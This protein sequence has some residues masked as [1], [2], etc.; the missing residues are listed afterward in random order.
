MLKQFWHLFLA[1]FILLLFGGQARAQTN[2][3][4]RW[5]FD[6]GG[7]VTPVLGT[8]NSKL[9][10]GWNITGGGGYNF[11]DNFGIVAQVMYDGL[12]VNNSVI[13][14]FQVPGAN[15]HIWG[16]TLNPEVRF[17]TSHRLG[18]YVIGGGG[19]YR[20]VINFT[21]PTT[22]V[23]NI[24]D[25]FFGYFYPTEV[26]ANQTIGTITKVGWGG[27][28]GGGLTYKLGGGP[29]R[30]FAEVRYHYIATQPRSI[31]IL[32]ITVGIRW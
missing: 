7:G 21:Q 5:N 26:A 25:P 22:E 18:A 20:R 11:N 27:N 12:G 8:A 1:S 4:G 28:I 16:F 15:S 19:Y 6:F 29:A 13:Q 31:Q 2:N 24:F 32:P 17:R 9:N 3:F 14:E 10:T 30:F 23:V